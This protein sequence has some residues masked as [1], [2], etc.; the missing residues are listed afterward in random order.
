M[1][2]REPLGRPGRKDRTLST[3]RAGRSQSLPAA[4]QPRLLRRVACGPGAES[5][6]AVTSARSSAKWYAR[7][8]DAHLDFVCRA[9]EFPNVD[10][11]HTFRQRNPDQQW[12]HVCLKP[13]LLA[14][15]TTKFAPVDAAS[16]LGTQINDGIDG[17]S[18]ML[19][20]RLP[21]VPGSQTISPMARPISRLKPWC[22]IPFPSLPSTRQSPSRALTMD[23]VELLTDNW[24]DRKPSLDVQPPFSDK[25]GLPRKN[26]CWTGPLRDTGG[27]ARRAAASRS[28]APETCSRWMW[29][30]RADRQVADSH[31]RRTRT[32]LPAVWRTV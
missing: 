4:T 8:L 26:P 2:A 21:A 15:K 6:S 24:R 13:N 3:S 10:L 17:F 7:R 30:G 25:D 5:V 22:R 20:R 31:R 32:E 12:V 27:L 29:A 28:D 16:E 14:L 19:E 1:V 23:R 11:L 9:V 18:A